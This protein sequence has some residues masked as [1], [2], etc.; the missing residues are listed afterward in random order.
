M[1]QNSI[2]LFR[3]AENLSPVMGIL[4][5]YLRWIRTVLLMGLLVIGVA[6]VSVYIV[7]F[8][9]RQNLEQRRSVLYTSVQQNLTKEAMFVALRSRIQA[10]KRIMQLQVSIAPYID[11]TLQIASPPQLQSFSLGDA[12]S[13]EISTKSPSVESAKDLLNI[14]IQLT[15]AGKIRKP[16]LTGIALDKEGIVT[17]GLTYIVVL[18]PATL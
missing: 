3:T 12:G 5:R 15:N 10:L 13:I 18:T 17:M 1:Q 7:F 2:N 16:T 4:E 9:Q 14:V 11:V 8:L 6:T